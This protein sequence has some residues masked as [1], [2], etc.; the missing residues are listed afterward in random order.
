MT[1]M[2]LTKEVSFH[3]N[4]VVDRAVKL[5]LPFGLVAALLISLFLTTPHED[6]LTLAGLLAAY[7]VPPA[8][9]E[10]VIP[11]GIGLGEPWWLLAM[12]IVVIDL[13]TSL[14]VALNL[15][16]TLKIPFVGPWI[17]RVMEGGHSYIEAHPWLG[18]LST[19]GLTI[20]VIVPFQGSGGMN[21]TILGRIMG[22][23]PA[24]VVGCV[25]TGSVISSFG[26]ALGT[27]ALLSLFRESV[28][29]GCGALLAVVALLGGIVLLWK[30]YA[31]AV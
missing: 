9:K 1:G 19:V 8:G 3:P 2:L 26:I 30:R 4:P 12:I 23:T 16:L 28:F 6:Y 24:V 17:G 18:R 14:F 22:L 10:S 11:V 20:F 29:L 25:L 13:S 15:D 7:I 27:T 31:P 21:A 5:A